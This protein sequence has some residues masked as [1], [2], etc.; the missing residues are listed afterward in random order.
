MQTDIT[1]HDT[2]QKQGSAMSSNPNHGSSRKEKQMSA[3][4]KATLVA[5]LVAL[6]LALAAGA[7]E[8]PKSAARAA[9]RRRG[10]RVRRHDEV[11]PEIRPRRKS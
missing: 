3:I 10:N 8:P 1:V 11:S 5:V 4:T 2:D 6:G 7:A 9:G